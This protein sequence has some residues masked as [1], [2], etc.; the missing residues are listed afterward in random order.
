MVTLPASNANLG[1]DDLT[2]NQGNQMSTE[3][4]QT[5]P[6]ITAAINR[7]FSEQ[8]PNMLDTIMGRLNH[9]QSNSIPPPPLYPPPLIPDPPPFRPENHVYNTTSKIHEWLTRFQKQKPR[10][11]N[12]AHDPMDACN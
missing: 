9:N 6:A 10:S 2:G 5:D 1:W 11:F 8:L 12:S 3:N 4:T 7:T